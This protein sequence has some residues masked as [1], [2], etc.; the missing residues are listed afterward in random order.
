M[1]LNIKYLYLKV[2]ELSTRVDIY[3]V[4]SEAKGWWVGMGGKDREK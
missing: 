2:I 3:I 1:T 4:E